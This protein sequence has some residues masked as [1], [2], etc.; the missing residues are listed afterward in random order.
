M[1]DHF[2][3]N[4]AN[5]SIFKATRGSNQPEVVK[6]PIAGENVE[7]YR[8]PYH[9]ISE[10]QAKLSAVDYESEGIGEDIG[11]KSKVTM[12]GTE[13]ALASLEANVFL[14]S[15]ALRVP[16]QVVEESTLDI[17]DINFIVASIK[18]ISGVDLTTKEI[19]DFF[20]ESEEQDGA[21]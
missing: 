1:E 21:N 13:F 10:Y 8:L 18:K 5:L 7:I 14:I 3:T 19:E 11:A 20:P 9:T 17:K 12:K 15:E 16:I 4:N 6:L 2:M